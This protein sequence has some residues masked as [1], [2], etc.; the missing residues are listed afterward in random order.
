MNDKISPRD[1]TK[2]S[3]EANLSAEYDFSPKTGVWLKKNAP[4]FQ[5]SDGDRV[6]EAIG[7]TLKNVGDKSV[8]S[9]E[10]KSLQTDWP[11]VY[12][13]SANRSNL[14]RPLAK[15]LLA[16]ARVLELGCG[17]GAVTRYLGE[18]AAEVIAVEG[19]ARRAAAA[20]ARCSDLVSVRVLVDEI[21]S[22][23]D[24]LGKFDVVTLIGVLEY[25]RRF[26]GAGAEKA[27]L[28][29]AKSFLKAGGSLILAIENKLGLKYLGGVPEDHLQRPWIGVT[30]GYADD[31]VRTWSRKELIGLLH[32]AGFER[33]EQFLALPDY[34]LPTTIITPAG[35]AA[36]PEEFD[37]KPILNNTKRP[38]EG[39]PVFNA[40]AA[41]GSVY[42]AGLLSDLADSLCFVASADESGE[43]FEAGELANHYGD[44][45]NLP[46]KYA[47]TVK[48][49]RTGD[50]IK[51]E[52][53]ALSPDPSSR[54]GEFYQTLE[55]E[56]YQKGELLLDAVRR[57][58]M[59]PDWTPGDLFAVLEP[60]AAILR[61]N[62]DKNGLCDG[63]L[64][65]LTPFNMMM[66]GDEVQLIDQ[67]WV[68]AKKLPLSYLLY[69][70]LN[71]TLYRLMPFRKSSRHNTATFSELF[72]EF[73]KTQNLP[74]NAPISP[75]YL[76]WQELKF[77]RFVKN[78]PRYVSHKDYKL[79]YV[80]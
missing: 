46:K 34:K 11:T 67:E 36:S 33:I 49:K 28:K 80:I 27:L 74:A 39:R 24:S 31:D 17:M 73:I 70:G 26:G 25:A 4:A 42:D 38:F 10:L 15:N 76:W 64:L 77:M 7:Q 50:L 53:R 5:Y 18:T 72:S 16:G 21:K 35:L 58:C 52:R 78:N 47:K 20:A 62:A 51:V 19:S 54:D 75:D 61:K 3:G 71:S 30:N 45:S 48:F 14:L 8:F 59:R 66:N 2:T 22:L 32:D 56:P 9:D 1:E 40:Q 13:F 65:D 12:Y 29:K 79:Q 69:R 63:K 57:V 6:E 41:W 23:P 43:T 60:W 68:A 55:D 44:L 37:L